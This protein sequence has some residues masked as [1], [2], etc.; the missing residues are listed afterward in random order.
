MLKVHVS[1]AKAGVDSVTRSMALEWGEDGIRANGV[2]PG[3]ISGTAGMLCL[4]L[5]PHSTSMLPWSYIWKGRYAS[6]HLTATLPLQGGCQFTKFLIHLKMASELTALPQ[7]LPPEQQV[8]PAPPFIHA[9]P[10][11]VYQVTKCLL[12]PG[13]RHRRK[14]YI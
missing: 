6:I 4:T 9:P 1:A 2:A 7:A 5:Q 14:S 3:P 12:H 11:Y 10:P 8:R 13:Q